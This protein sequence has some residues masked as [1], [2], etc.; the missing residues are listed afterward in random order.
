[1]LA[2]LQLNLGCRASLEHSHTTG[3]LCQA[4]LQLLAVVV[5]IGVCDLGANLCHAAIKCG[6]VASALNNGGLV[7]GDNNLACLTQHLKGCGIQ[8]Q[9]NLFGNNLAAGEDRNIS[10][11][12]LATVTETGCL[13][14]N[15]LDGA[16]HLVQ[17]EQS[18]SLA[19]NILGNN[20]QRLAGLHDLLKN[21]NQILHV[22]DLLVDHQDVG[23][24][25]NGF[26]TLGVGHEVA[27]EEALIEAHTLGEFQVQA[28]GVGFL[29]G[30]HAFLADL[31][32]SLSDQ[33][34]DLLIARRDGCGCRDLFLSLNLFRGV[35][36]GLGDLL[37]SLLDTALEAQRVSTGSHV[38]QAL[39]HK[40][41]G[42]HGC[43]GGTVTCDIVGLLG[44]LFDEFSANLFIGVFKLDL[45]GDGNTVVGDR[46]C[47]PRLLK[48]D[49][50]A[51]GAK[52]YLN[53]I[54]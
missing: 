37:N 38:A 15:G 43:G 28:E 46:G 29:N 1:M 32:H 48:H 49:V 4:L 23:V 53:G 3:E 11:H 41:L 34:T 45:F 39:T 26:L 22:R 44:Y 9:A 19:L 42:E 51:T 21:G 5:G 16:A 47:A 35:E 20:Q 27:G 40:R 25:Q 18:Q 36:Q 17:H 14:G 54:G 13:H 33:L 7:L 6:G 10:H 52:S 50:A 24:F 30:N 2:F 31:L 8:G 12:S